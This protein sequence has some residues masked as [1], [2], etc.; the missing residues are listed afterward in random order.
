MPITMPCFSG[1]YQRPRATRDAKLRK[2]AEEK[3]DRQHHP[4]DEPISQPIN[5]GNR[6]IPIETTRRAWRR[7][8]SDTRGRSEERAAGA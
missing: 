4:Y 7:D 3:P 6:V 8:R 5:N 1:G 2:R